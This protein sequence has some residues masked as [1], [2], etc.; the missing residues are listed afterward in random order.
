[1]QRITTIIL[2]LLALAVAATAEDNNTLKT[3]LQ[4]IA[5]E[6][7]TGT[8]EEYKAFSQKQGTRLIDTAEKM[9]A[10]PNLPQENQRYALLMKHWG[11]AR[12]F[13]FNLDEYDQQSSKF[14]DSIENIPGM[15]DLYRTIMENLYGRASNVYTIDDPK[16]RAEAF[17][18]WRDRFL[19]YMLKYCTEKD[20]RQLT[21]RMG[22]TVQMCDPDDSFGLVESMVDKL[23]PLLKEQEKSQETKS[24]SNMVQGMGRR[25]RL[26]G[27]PIEY[28]GVSTNGELIDVTNYRGKVVFL[29]FGSGGVEIHKKLYNALH[30]QGLVMITHDVSDS[31]EVVRKKAEDAGIP[32][33]I[34]CRSACHEKNLEDYYENW[35]LT[36][37]LFLIDRNGKVIHSWAL[38]FCPA[39][40]EELKKLFPGQE[41]ILTEISADL[42]QKEADEKR[43]WAED[44]KK[45]HNPLATDLSEMLRC[46]DDAVRSYEDY[47]PLLPSSV[48]TGVIL[49]LADIL[50]AIPD[51][52]KEEWGWSARI[53]LETLQ[54]LAEQQFDENPEVNPAEIFKQWEQTIVELERSPRAAEVRGV[55]FNSKIDLIFAMIPAYLGRTTD[56]KADSAKEIAK[57]WIA[58]NKEELAYIHSLPKEK[59]GVGTLSYY[60]DMIPRMLIDV[61]EE[62][63]EDGSQGLV[64]SF[65]DEL[66]PILDNSGFYELQE[67]AAHLKGVARRHSSVGTEFEFECLLLDGKKIN[68][69]DLR[70]KIVLVNFWATWCGPCVR[71]F[72]NM[73]TQYEKYKSKGYEMIALG[74][75]AEVE[76]IVEFQ[77]KNQYPW[78]VGSLVQ[79]K[80]A[81]L[82]DYYKY[83]GV[84]GIPV[85][86]LLDRNGK[87][88]FRMTGSD[89]E[90]LNKAL[91]KA[92]GE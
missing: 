14:A 2:I 25:T 36:S 30:D 60:N 50:L 53:K 87:V 63:D 84:E 79:S 59:Q 9:L 42:A 73:K 85:T 43:E 33:I 4:N 55:V 31:R 82:V 20:D 18:K 52:S 27:N 47:S 74:T 70:G 15:T 48:Y 21:F 28:K 61:M 17:I 1:M 22:Q 80:E 69:K 56:S 39:A 40:C 58:L 62:I 77:N 76:K 6:P 10:T 68:V 5:E 67:R 34:T 16:K 49:E 89:D 46:I 54:K 92:F 26:T 23:M 90:T 24:H 41:K 83:Y 8:P 37:A 71:E 86:F 3:Q 57:R 72:P 7:F 51:A 45:G 29:N 38:G 66:V 64:V 75:D 44:I 91:E 81:G 78:L 32:W 11:L 19:P 35:G 65:C 88:L 13:G 12:K